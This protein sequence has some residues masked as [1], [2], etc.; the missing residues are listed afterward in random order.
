MMDDNQVRA[1][2]NKAAVNCKWGG[3]SAILERLDEED[4]GERKINLTKVE[5]EMREMISE[6]MSALELIEDLQMKREDCNAIE[7]NRVFE[8]CC[9]RC[10][11]RIVEKNPARTVVCTDC[12]TKF[13]AKW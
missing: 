3:V 10:Q 5:I 6:A 12:D 13:R 2:L 4:N 7:L 8:W 9:P 1:E 11:K